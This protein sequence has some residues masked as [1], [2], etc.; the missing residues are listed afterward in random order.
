[1]LTVVHDQDSSN[2]DACGSRSLL[3]EIVRD[4]A[5]QMLAAALAA[6]VAAY[7]DAHAGEVDENGHRLV[8][9]NGYHREREVLTA[10]GAVTVIAPRVNDKRIDADTAERRRFSSAILP[11]WARKSPQMT[12]VLPLLY[13]HGLSTSD[14]GPALE[15]FLGSGAGLSA[16]T[17]TR[18]TAQWQD[19]AKAFGERDLSGTDYVYL[20]VDGIHL[21]VR[22]EQEKLCLLVMIGVRSDGRKE[23]VGLADGYRES[24]ESWADLLRSCRRRGMTA[25][26]LAVGDGALG[27][28]KAMREVFP[29]TRE[30]RC[31][32]HKQANVLSCL[33]KSAHPGALAAMREIYNAEDIDHAQVAIKAFEVDYGAKYPKAVAKIV[34]DADVLLEFYRYPAE[35]WIHLRTTNPIESTFATVRLR[36]KVTKGPGSRAA[37]IAMA[38]KL[39]DAAQARWRA[40]NAPHLVAL[41]R[42]G[43]VF[44]KGKLLERPVD[45]TPPEPAESAET[46]VA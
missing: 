9:R 42:A 36:T 35:H 12:E 1:M 34:D 5:R 19:E 45:I 23:L 4:G 31:W 29:A 28:W 17:I 11:A 33:P 27:F 10:A 18:L 8:V 3:D 20:W 43:A 44:H 26:V 22:L 37:G 39:I 25:P 15:Q 30:Q 41:V 21:K 38:Y 32:F 14:F 2:E 40:V 13:L 16:T 46:E 24:T 6:E 7:I